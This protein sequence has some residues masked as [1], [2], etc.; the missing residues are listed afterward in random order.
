MTDYFEAKPQRAVGV[1]EF[2]GAVVP[3]KTSPELVARLEAKGLK[4]V[5]YSQKQG[6]RERAIRE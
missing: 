1:E 2:R 4:I 6:A 3:E 5:R